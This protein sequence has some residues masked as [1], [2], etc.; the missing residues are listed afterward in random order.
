MKQR[1][2]VQAVIENGD[3]VLL[4]HR[5]QGRPAIVGKFEL[6][7]GTLDHGEQPEDALR[8]H[9]ISATGL[10]APIIKLADVISMV[11]RE[12]GDVQHVLI[13]YSVNG[14]SETDFIVLGRS[15]D[16]YQWIKL[17]N[18]QQKELRDSAQLLLGIYDMDEVVAEAIT[19]DG[20]N[21]VGSTTDTGSAIIYSDG[22]SRGN[23]GPSAAAYVI[24][25]RQQQVLDRGGSYLGI[26]TNNLAEY[27][28]VQL[29]LERALEMGLKKL[30]LRI[31]SMLVVNQMKGLYQIK[32]RE[33]WPINERVRL[34]ISQ[35][36]K[37]SFTHVPREMNQLA[38]V[39][40]NELLDEHQTDRAVV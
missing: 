5:S 4:L 7:G 17:L 40:V 15:Y 37:V 19:N 1:V 18:I 31:D 22:G 34:L 21:D 27:H 39:L 9:V 30:E 35:F 16:S 38:D 33:L 24:M 23:P 20:G 28:G 2:V 25:D 26:T 6:P 13:S 3:K 36:E 32:N 29:G 10:V 8:R 12:E 11:N 14:L